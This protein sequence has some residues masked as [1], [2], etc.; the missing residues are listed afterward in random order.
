MKYYILI[1]IIFIS[2]MMFTP[3]SRDDDIRK[4]VRQTAR[5]AVASQ[6]DKS[7]LIQNLHFGYCVGFWWSIKEIYTPEEIER[8]SNINVKE[9]EKKLLNLQDKI[10]KRLV[11]VCPDYASDID[12]YLAKISGN[13]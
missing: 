10:T 9:F 4:L 3:K 1:L 5:W 13:I 6:Q 12:N 11:Q 8:A 7:P 2:S